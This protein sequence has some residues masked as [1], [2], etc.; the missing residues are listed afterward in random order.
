MENIIFGMLFSHLNVSMS[1]LAVTAGSPD[2]TEVVIIG[3]LFVL[4]VLSALGVVT[5]LLGRV[6]QAVDGKEEASSTGSACAQA[7]PVVSTASSGLP[8]DVQAVITAAV[9]TVLEERPHRIV[10]VKEVH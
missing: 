5:A 8:K 4:L 7:E 9:H 1:T 6:F 10:A 3:F 2:S